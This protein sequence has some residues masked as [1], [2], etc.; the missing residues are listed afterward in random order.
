MDGWSSRT[1]S[2]NEAN[3]SKSAS[4]NFPGLSVSAQCNIG[5]S[6]VSSCSYMHANTQ[7]EEEAMAL[8]LA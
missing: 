1:G 2:L 5:R 3:F 7:S 6:K 8:L 4:G